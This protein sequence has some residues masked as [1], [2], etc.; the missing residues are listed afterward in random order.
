MWGAG[1]GVD[2]GYSCGGQGVELT[3]A[4]VVG[5]GGVVL[6]RAI[7]VFGDQGYDCGEAGGWC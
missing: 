2:Q 3:R 7:V 6:T 4:I 5:G 1:D